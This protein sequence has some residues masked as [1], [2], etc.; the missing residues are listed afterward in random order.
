[1]KTD[2]AGA[3]GASTLR[4]SQGGSDE[5]QKRDQW[6]CP[7]DMSL[8]F[9]ERATCRR[10]GFARPPQPQ[11]VATTMRGSGGVPNATPAVAGEWMCKCQCLNFA[12]RAA[13]RSCLAPRLGSA[14]PALAPISPGAGVRVAMRGSSGGWGREDVTHSPSAPAAHPAVVDAADE[15]QRVDKRL[16]E[17]EEEMAQLRMRRA[18]EA[19]RKTGGFVSPK[20]L[21][22]AIYRDN[23]QR[24]GFVPTFAPAVPVADGV[25]V[26]PEATFLD[27]L[28]ES[29][30]TITQ[31]LDY[32]VFRENA[33]KH[34]MIGAAIKAEIRR[35]KLRVYYRM[36]MVGERMAKVV[37][38]DEAQGEMPRQQVVLRP[39]GV[40]R[41][42]EMASLA[43]SVGDQRWDSNLA[44]EVDMVWNR[45]HLRYVFDDQSQRVLD[46][47]QE[48][49]ERRAALRWTDEEQK[50][51]VDA[52]KE[53]G[54]EFHVIATKKPFRVSEVAPKTTHEII[55]FYYF[56]KHR[57]NL[58]QIASK[59]GG[60]ARSVARERSSMSSSATPIPRE[61][62]SMGITSEADVVAY[63]M[64]KSKA[65]EAGA[66][67]SASPLIAAVV[68]APSS[69][70]DV[71]V[72]LEPIEKRAREEDNV[73]DGSVIKSETEAK[74]DVKFDIEDDDDE[75]E[76]SSVQSDV[77][78]PEISLEPGFTVEANITN[79]SGLE[80]EI[81]FESLSEF[82][83]D[84]AMLARDTGKSADKCAAFY[85][86]NEGK[87]RKT[88]HRA[89]GVKL[90][91]GLWTDEEKVAYRQFVI[92]N[93]RDWSGLA[94][95]IPDKT[96][97]QCRALWSRFKVRLGL[98]E[99]FNLWK[100]EAA[101][102]AKTQKKEEDV[103]LPV[104]LSSAVEEEGMSP[105]VSTRPQMAETQDAGF[106]INHNPENIKKE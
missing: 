12:S 13:C 38:P 100:Q 42:Q 53:Y 24:T 76:V 48:N 90:E 37:E 4:H 10:C 82:G 70:S 81:F 68:S 64:A 35:R 27:P 106:I 19:G 87:V 91:L 89:A 66:S 6:K 29:V 41:L 47:E 22:E 79:W 63:L 95:F 54:K 98:R 105:P 9:L 14:G 73:G 83:P 103:G 99:A 75:A 104:A 32:P 15:I 60:W 92:E 26:A 80:M 39:G 28:L 88:L 71:L 52:Y 44:R 61:L 33:Q 8:N 17:V 51:F 85:L 56:V 11:I 55:A 50:A 86:Q 77:V 72:K 74:G 20:V 45:D 49:A 46:P 97:D 16:T 101:R 93:G 43:Q 2:D 69:L 96:E 31:P 30:L 23:Q 94:H 102:P 40:M 57:I 25:V 78:L 62:V 7:Q 59:R 67:A 84:W 5:M 34:Q 36:R 65:P 1:V 21:V 58:K 18:E 3:I